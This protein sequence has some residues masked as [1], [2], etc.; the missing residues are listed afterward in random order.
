MNEIHLR[1]GMSPLSTPSAPSDTTVK[2]VNVF[3]EIWD[4]ASFY[5][6]TTNMKISLPK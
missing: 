1:K 4:L 2:G 5:R 6:E 3:E